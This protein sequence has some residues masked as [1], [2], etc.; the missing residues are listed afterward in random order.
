[1]K[2][3][4]PDESMEPALRFEGAVELAEEEEALEEGKKVIKQGLSEYFLFAIEGREDIQNKEP[5][6]LVSMECMR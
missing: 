1:M 2:V 6:R 4:Q 5:K 3:K